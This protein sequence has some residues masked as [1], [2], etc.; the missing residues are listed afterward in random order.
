MRPGLPDRVHRHG[1]RR[2]EEPLPHPLGRPGDVRRAARGVGACGGR[3]G[4]SRTRPTPTST[5]SIPKLE[6]I[7]EVDHDPKGMLEILEATQAAYG[8]LPV[9]ALKRIS[10]RTGAW[11][12]MIYGT[13]T[14]YRHLRS[15]RPRRSPLADGDRQRAGRARDL[16]LAGLDASLAGQ[17]RAEA[18]RTHD[19]HDPPDAAILA[20]D[21]APARQRDPPDLDAAREAGAFDR[22][23]NGDP[24]AGAA[25]TIATVAASGLRGRGGAGFP[26]AEKWRAAAKP[27]WRTAAAGR[28]ATMARYVVANGYGADPASQTDRTL[29]ERDPYARDRGR[30]DRGLRDR[31]RRG[32]R[33]GPGR[34]DRGDPA[35][36]RPRSMRPTEAGFIGEDVLG[37]RPAIEMR[38]GRS[39]AR[40]C[41]AR[42]RSC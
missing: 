30:R 38:S 37:S 15:S 20:G 11:Y 40:T 3:A 18:G 2:H 36:S 29:L 1:R 33:R 8:H 21:P 17:A 13:A 32:D 24:R 23:P 9:A 28:T 10:Q 16:V 35:R 34:G 22:P 5:R 4:R 25:A 39:R 6:A 7:L 12:A 19:A 31:R 14:Y 42:R 41:S 26:T 27:P